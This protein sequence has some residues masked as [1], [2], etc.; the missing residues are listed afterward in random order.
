[1]M[2][3]IFWVMFVTALVMGSARLNYGAP[4]PKF[5]DS[6]GGNKHNLS[7]SNTNV[8]FKATNSTDMRA[9]QI[10]IFCHTPHMHARRPR[11]GTA[12]TQPRVSATIHRAACLSTWMQPP[13]RP[14][15]M[16]RSPM[17][18]PD[19]ASAATTG[20]RL[21]GPCLPGYR[22]RSTAACTRR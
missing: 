15:I 22:S 3:R 10:C 13:A 18:H 1:M 19:F 9:R 11:S 20:S 16:L 5:T 6:G 7:Y 21:L 12:A 2:T 17:A 14:A 4:G 8:N